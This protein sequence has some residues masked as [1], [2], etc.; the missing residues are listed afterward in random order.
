MDET[1]KILLDLQKGLTD[2]KTKLA[3]LKKNQRDSPETSKSRQERIR[4]AIGTVPLLIIRESDGG[5]KAENQ[6]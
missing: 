6:R 1:L 5:S 3:D 4:D 2:L